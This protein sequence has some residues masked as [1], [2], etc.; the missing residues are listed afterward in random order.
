MIENTFCYF[1]KKYCDKN[2]INAAT[3]L[4]DASVIYFLPLLHQKYSD[5]NFL[6]RN[7]NQPITRLWGDVT[8]TNCNKEKGGIY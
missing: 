8:L 5:Q 2:L 7:Q 1:T 3:Q 4:N 6:Y